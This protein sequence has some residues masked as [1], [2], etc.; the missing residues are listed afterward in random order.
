MRVSAPVMRPLAGQVVTP[1]TRN[2]TVL[3][4]SLSA[5]SSVR[6]LAIVTRTS[7]RLARSGEVINTGASL[8]MAH[9]AALSMISGLASAGTST[10][11]S[12]GL[13]QKRAASTAVSTLVLPP[14]RVKSSAAGA[15]CKIRQ[16]EIIPIITT[17]SAQ[18]TLSSLMLRSIRSDRFFAFA[19]PASCAC[20]DRFCAS[21]G[22]S[23][24]SLDAFCVSVGRLRH[25]TRTGATGS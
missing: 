19:R 3:S 15:G 4:D 7:R 17:P 21:S 10:T 9:L 1:S 25:W 18:R 24:V 6:Q 23:C 16:S 11:V 8:R 20:L 22:G 12:G 2:V 13:S 5:V 14:T